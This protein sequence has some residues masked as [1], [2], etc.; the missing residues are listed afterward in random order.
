M[1][2][3]L[4]AN[5]TAWSIVTANA[6]TTFFASAAVGDRQF[7]WLTWKDFSITVSVPGWT[8]VT[9]F[10]DGAVSQADS[11]GSMKVGCWYRD[12][13]PG[14]GSPSSWTITFSSAPSVAAGMAQLW[15]KNV[16]EV[17]DQPAFATAAWPSQSTGTVAASGAVNIK[18]G[19]VAMALI[20]IRNDSVSF[21]RPTTAI[22]RSSGGSPAFNGN[23]VELPA[24]H[25]TTTTGNDLSADFGYRLVT[26]GA[27]AVVLNTAITALSTAE[28]GAILWLVQNVSP[29]TGRNISTA[30]MRASLY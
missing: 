14:D 26:T 29:A 16:G 8:K 6:P 24:A 3:S 21:T 17:W 1:A 20:G 2:I 19:A 12:F 5:D 4:K 30:Q 10:T 23:Y 27:S 13:Q 15:Q 7:L 18:N 28:T 11:V 22:D 25:A 9:E